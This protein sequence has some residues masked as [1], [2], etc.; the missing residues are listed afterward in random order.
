MSIAQSLLPEYDHE[1]ATTRKY[2]ERTPLAQK[3]WKPHPKSMALGQLA[4]H[5]S[6][7]PSWMV[8]TLTRTEL[9]LNPPGGTGYTPPKLTTVEALVASFDGHVKAGREALAA[10]GDADFMVPWALKSAGATIFSMP[11]IAVLRGFVMSHMIHHRGQFSVYLRL[12]D[13]LVPSS[14]GPS[15]DEM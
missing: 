7:L 9:D 15:A 4:G 13:V 2:L 14:Y 8:A 6:E 12:R 11:R 1:M 10:A 5:L 3:D